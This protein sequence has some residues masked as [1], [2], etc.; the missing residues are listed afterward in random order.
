MHLHEECVCRACTPSV[1]QVLLHFCLTLTRA[2]R[3]LAWCARCHHKSTATHECD[4]Q[5]RA[6]TGIG[7]RR[8]RAYEHTCTHLRPLIHTHMRTHWTHQ[9]HTHEHTDARAHIVLARC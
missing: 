3:Q 2:Y 9:V 5:I 1:L 7:G 8:H 6:S 4:P